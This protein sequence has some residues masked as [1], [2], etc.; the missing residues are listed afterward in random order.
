[1]PDSEAALD[2]VI[3]FPAAGE[4]YTHGGKYGAYSYDT[5]PAGTV[6][7]GQTRRRFLGMYD[8]MEEARAD[9]PGAGVVDGSG[10]FRAGQVP[11]EPPP[12]FDPAAAGETWAEEEGVAWPGHGTGD[13][14]L[15]L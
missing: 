6:L 10:A 15:E 13:R 3:E 5:Y 11:R 4:T 8:S 7:A 9:W 2:V 12:W 14:G 1:M